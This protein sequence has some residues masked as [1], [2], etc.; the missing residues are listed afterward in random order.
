MFFWSS[1][2]GIGKKLPTIFADKLPFDSYFAE[3][4]YCTQLGKLVDKV[5]IG[6]GPR[7]K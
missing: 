3:E 2:G 5:A 6:F 1:Y 4:T 7:I